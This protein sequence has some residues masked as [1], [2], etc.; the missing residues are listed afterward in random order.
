M[1]A[2][3]E[4]AISRALRRTALGAAG[5]LFCLVG[6]VFLTVAAW[7]ALVAILGVVQ[8]ALVIG[9]AFFGI[10]AIFMGL[11]MRKPSHHVAHPP[12]R[13]PMPDLMGAF[14]SGMGQGTRAGEQFK[15]A[16]H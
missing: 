4:A 1:F 3:L 5:A 7:V 13:Q 9:G 12:V 6:L 16:R 8:A 15:S 2:R 11:S 10:G 14:M